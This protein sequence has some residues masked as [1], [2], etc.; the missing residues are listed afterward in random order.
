MRRVELSS[1][2]S[3][4]NQ[5]DLRAERDARLVAFRKAAAGAG[6]TAAETQRLWERLRAEAKAIRL[7][8]HSTKAG[9]AHVGRLV[10]EALVSRPA[11]AA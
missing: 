10:L 1:F 2:S 7:G 5:P 11:V 8:L 9:H 6:L 3:K 4:C